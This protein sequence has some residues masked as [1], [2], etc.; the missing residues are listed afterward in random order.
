MYQGIK[1]ANADDVGESTDAKELSKFM[2]QSKKTFHHA[3]S[4]AATV[5]FVVLYGR[6]LS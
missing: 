2:A 4:V 1:A 6:L 5:T 3:L